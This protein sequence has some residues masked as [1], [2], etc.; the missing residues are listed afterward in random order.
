MTNI[1]I[2]NA[3]SE[4]LQVNETQLIRFFKAQN[5]TFEL[6]VSL[7]KI[8]SSEVKRMLD[9]LFSKRYWYLEVETECIKKTIIKWISTT[10]H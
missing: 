2:F 8:D 10:L 7:T 1:T 9:R 6:N 5:S 3:S 4:V